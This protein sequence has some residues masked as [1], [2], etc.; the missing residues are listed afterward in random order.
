MKVISIRKEQILIVFYI[1]VILI[2]VISSYNR[3]T[4][5]TFAMP[6]SKKV[7]LIDAGHGGF[8]PGKIGV[9]GTLEKD[10]NLKIAQKLQSHL[11]QGGSYVIVTRDIDEA[12]GNTKSKDMKERKDIANNSQ[13]DMLISI[14]QNSYTSESVTGAQVFYYDNSEDSKKLAEYVQAELKDFLG[15]KNNREAKSNSSYYI[16]KKTQMPAIIVECGFLSSPT[17]TQKLIDDEYQE[18]IAWAIY[19]GV[20]SYYK[21]N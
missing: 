13:A 3:E 9:D 17:E 14:H 6:V 8:D 21:E 2:G 11:E 20:I 16:L 18:K 4:V 15:Q 7:I 5:E 12:L 19:K 1:I 10:I